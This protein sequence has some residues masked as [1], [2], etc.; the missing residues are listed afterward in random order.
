[1]E[2]LT[3][4]NETILLVEEFSEDSRRLWESLRQ[5][6]CA[7]RAITLSENGFLPEGVTSVYGYFLGGYSGKEGKERPR[8]FNEISV[9]EYWEITG[10]ATGGSVRDLHRERAKIFFAEPK[11]RRF[12]CAVDWYDEKGTVCFTDHYNRY[13]FLY[14][15]TVFDAKG[16]R[17]NR[18]Y[19][20]AE[21]RTVIEENFITKAIIL[22]E[23]KKI[24]V[25]PSKLKFLLYFAQKEGLQ[26]KRICYNS[27][28]TPF[29]VSKE[30]E[31]AGTDILFWQEP[32]RKDIPGNM[33]SIL[34]GTIGR[35]KAIYVQNR[36][37]CEKLLALGA[38]PAVVKSLGYIYPFERENGKRPE[39]L[40]CTNSDRIEKIQELAE[41]LPEVRFHIAALTEMSATLLRLEKYSNIRLYA[42]ASM[43]TLDSL[44]GCCDI[45]L[46]INQ[47]TEIA[48]AVSRAF[49]QNQLIYAFDETKHNAAY[50]MKK[51]CCPAAEYEKMISDLKQLLSGKE[52]WEK[53]LLEQR[54]YAMAENINSYRDAMGQK[55]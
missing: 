27:L 17:V 39:A 33:A 35:T 20:N 42:C 25:F 36:A 53:R 13:G 19:F 5:A 9:P 51:N 2:E 31:G 32:E 41:A 44:F 50:V 8:Y 47:G 26:N 49:L 10:S 21:G 48:A 16:Q 37:A 46:D 40:I 1:M 6:K 7:D 14:A 24:T 4:V 15:R 52:E 34:N 11:H 23:G 12:V 55:K 38:D 29:F 43:S 28:S 18:T 45:Y 3:A 30:L 22:T 54:E